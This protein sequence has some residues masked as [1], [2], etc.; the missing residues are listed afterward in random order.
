M[1]LALVLCTSWANATPGSP[2]RL[3][4][5]E[6]A[7]QA[8]GY[9]Y[10]NVLADQVVPAQPVNSCLWV[11][12]PS[13]VF[14]PVVS[15]RWPPTPRSCIR[16]SGR[17]A[18]SRGTPCRYRTD[19]GRR[20][21]RPAPQELLHDGP[22]RRSAGSMPARLRVSRTVPRGTLIP[23]L[24]S[25][26]LTGCSLACSRRSASRRTPASRKYPTPAASAR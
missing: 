23:G 5:I 25:S 20:S 18:C 10:G 3:L 4:G 8:A 7:S 13:L 22:D 2:L 6:G 26:S 9:L 1:V 16:R 24:A 11:R 21:P 19:R 15:C 12:K 14:C 17:V